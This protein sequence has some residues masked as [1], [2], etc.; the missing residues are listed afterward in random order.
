MEFICFTASKGGVGTSRILTEVSYSLCEQ[1]YKC[2]AVDLRSGARSLEIYFG[3]E[4]S[5]VFDV[6][7][8]ENDLCSINDVT[9]K[10]NDN[11]FYLPCS[12]SNGIKNYQRLLMAIH[13]SAQMF[14]F[15]LVDMPYDYCDCDVFTKTVI[16]T[17]CEP[18]SVRCAEKLTEDLKN[19]KKYLIINKIDADLINSDIH[20]NVDDICD[21]CG[22]S[23]LGFVPYDYKYFEFGDKKQSECNKAFK[24]IAQRLNNKSVCA[25][26]FEVSKNYK[27]IFARR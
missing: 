11:L 9:V 19:V 18:S 20:F 27:K 23:P 13:G 1:G 4:D 3:C 14:D 2:L 26:D 12:L 7:D 25:I 24:N 10:I 6:C 21:R 16:V 17:T 8:F 22:I 5:F 15:V